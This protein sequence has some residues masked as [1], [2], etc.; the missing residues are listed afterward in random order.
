MVRFRL[1]LTLALCVLFLALTMISAVN[2]QAPTPDPIDLTGTALVAEVTQTAAVGGF[3]AQSA[4]SGGGTATPLAGLCN[5]LS[6]R[7]LPDVAD[8]VQDALMRNN[9]VPHSVEASAIEDT[10]DCL[11]FDIRETTVQIIINVDFDDINDEAALGGLL[12]ESLNTAAQTR[13]TTLPDVRLTIGFS[14]GTQR[15]L[16]DLPF[17]PALLAFAVRLGEDDALFIDALTAYSEPD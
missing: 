15:R 8:E 17:S 9:I 16:F 14:A 5:S 2:G 1:L 13:L 7:I 4:P 11:T 3:S 6:F 10:T 12:R